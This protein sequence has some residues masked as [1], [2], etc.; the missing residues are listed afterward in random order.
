MLIPDTTGWSIT[1]KI[2]WLRNCTPQQWDAVCKRC[3]ICCLNKLDAYEAFG[4]R[5]VV[6]THC[7][8]QHLNV[9]SRLCNV[10]NDRLKTAGN[11]CKKVDLDIVL[12]G[13]LLPDSCGYR[14]FIYGPARVP[15]QIDWS[16]VENVSNTDNADVWYMVSRIIPGSYMWGGH[17]R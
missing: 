4:I 7:A 5:G 12:Q 10:Y 6:Y 16:R 1:E 14:E 9:C 2:N 17:N 8:C 15:A 3:G 13:R 11:Q